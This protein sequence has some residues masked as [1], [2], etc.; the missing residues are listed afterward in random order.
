MEFRIT[1][2]TDLSV[3][4]EYLIEQMNSCNIFLLNGD[5]GAGKT[6]L[7][8]NW[9]GTIGIRDLVSSPTFS[10]VNEYR[11]GDFSVFHMDMYRLTSIDEALDIGIEDYFYH[12]KS[13]SIIEWPNLILDLISPPFISIDIST[14]NN[15]ERI[16]KIKG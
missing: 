7:V 6:T 10:I 3:V 9:M 14:H 13:Y 8:K 2:I 11:G 16:I 4:S 12:Q 1:N 5:L 15:S